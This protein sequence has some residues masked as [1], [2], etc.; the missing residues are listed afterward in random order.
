MV[1]PGE[2]PFSHAK[3]SLA[4]DPGATHLVVMVRVHVLPDGYLDLPPEVAIDAEARLA[5]SISVQ[6]SIEHP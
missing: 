4:A 3:F 2:L 1:S 6:V 5:A